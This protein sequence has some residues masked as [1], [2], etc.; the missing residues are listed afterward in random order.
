MADL[1]K[2]IAAIKDSRPPT[3]DRFTYLTILESHMSP[4][5][6]PTLNDILQDAD[7]TQEIGWDLI[8]MLLPLPG[9]E[10][11][12]ETIARV[13][14]PREV[15]LKVLEALDNI[16]HEE[17]EQTDG[18]EDKPS[19]TERSG[20]TQQFITL[21]GMLAILH[22]RLKTKYPSRFL[23]NTLQ[24]VHRA[25]R[26]NQEMTAAVINLVHS[27]TGQRARPPLP[28]R[29]SSVNVANPDQ[30]GDASKN[31]PDP[32]AEK[33][34]REDPDESALQE[35]LL[36]SFV[37]CILEAYVN[38]NDIAWAQRL[39]EFYNPTK[40]VPGRMSAMQ[41]FRE[42]QELLAR[43]AVVGQLAALTSD[44]GLTEASDT[45][46][47]TLVQGPMNNDPLGETDDL[48]SPEDIALSTGGSISLLAYWIFSSTVFDA[49]HPTPAMH[50]F[51]EHFALL[52][53]L[54]QDDA[55][56][57]I[58]SAPGTI[59][60]L[61][62]LGL[63]LEENKLISAT[64]PPAAD[65]EKTKSATAA[66]A[67]NNNPSGDFMTYHH[68]LT[69]VAVYHPSLAVRN[70]AGSLAGAILHDDPVVDDR[71]RI[72]EDLLENC[73]FT[74]LKACAVTWLRE[75]LLAA[76]SSSTSAGSGAG[77]TPGNNIFATPDALD[78]VQYAVFPSL[79]FLKEADQTSLAEYWIANAAFLI[80]AANFALFLW[81]GDGRLEHLVPEGMDAA[82]GERWAEPLLAA[83]QRYLRDV[84]EG[85][86]GRGE[87][88]VG[89]LAERLERL[90]G[91]EGFGGLERKGSREV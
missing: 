3:T 84:R 43:D 1:S 17:E 21:L 16:Q 67:E 14:N 63:W 8:E 27:L 39:L 69:L 58:R 37:T 90:R 32:E 75:E 68:L 57:Q 50:I 12:L 52:E 61:V 7:L 80:Q 11:C 54:L 26:P 85:E 23:G 72:L 24:T 89:I 64:G 31:A 44:L 5:I 34:G 60:S 73:M 87:M 79:G 77:S 13:G 66:V 62:A 76:L 55:H 35:R 15:I 65:D 30:N 28:T 59:A 36:L 78:T 82:V 6:L 86:D 70:A 71:L 22:R 2:S 4:E 25:Y 9:C 33:D 53:Q 46:I 20:P 41:A 29:K 45:F 18:E 10:T 19:S 74:N 47:K 88:E 42:D 91:T 40:I 48:S 81:R 83:A 56:A 49:N 38:K 51:P